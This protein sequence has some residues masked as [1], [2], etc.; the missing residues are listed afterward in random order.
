MK[1]AYLNKKFIPLKKAKVSILDR[2]FL[3]G[4]GIFETM[5]SYDGGV[6][7]LEKH[8]ERLYR[9]LKILDIKI[10]LNKKSI[11]KAV[12]QL[13]NKNGLKNAYIKIVVTRGS[14][15]GLLIPTRSTKATLAIYALPY[16]DNAKEIR[17]KG[18]KIQIASTS[19][20]ERSK[21]AGNKTL[22]YM[23]N[24]LCRYEA[25]IKGFDDAV[26]INTRGHVSEVTSSN[27]FLVKNNTIFTPCLKAGILPGIIRQEIIDISKNSLKTRIKETFLKRSFLYS[28]DEVFITNSLKGIVPVIKIGRNPVGHGKPGPITKALENMLGGRIESYCRKHKK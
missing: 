8:L 18:I 26:L 19:S 12:Y 15:S 6:F 4:D 17:E 14:S 10:E 25:R 27:I 28:A 23:D 7:L 3:Y 9:S 11:E 16:K 20:N 13:L 2:G 24:I 22:N 1:V 21:I 5:R